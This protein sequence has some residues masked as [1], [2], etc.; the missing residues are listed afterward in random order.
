VYYELLT[1]V[2]KSQLESGCAVLEWVMHSQMH[3]SSLTSH[4]NG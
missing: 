3:S 1:Y 2:Y 4:S